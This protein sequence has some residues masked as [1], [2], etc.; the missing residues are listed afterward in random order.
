MTSESELTSDV[1][2]FFNLLTGISEMVGWSKLTIAPTGLRK[3]FEELI[4]REISSSTPDKPGFIMAK[5]NSLEDKK[6]CQALYKASQ[7]GVKILLNVRGICCLRP[8]L[9]KISENI[10]VISIVD[11]FLEHARIFYF[12]NGGH[13]EIYLSSADMM[14]RNLDRRLETL[15]PINSLK[16]RKRLYN[17]LKIYFSDNTKACEMNSEGTYKRKSNKNKKVR[18]QEIFYNEAVKAAELSKCEKMKFIPLTK[19]K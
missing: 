4:E 7:A 11:R 16:L 13:D 14:G 9:K 6:I 1:A 10:E 8:G 19:P 3:K 5:M 15:F 2:A 17:I 18:A 12:S